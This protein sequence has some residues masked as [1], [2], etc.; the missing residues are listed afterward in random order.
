MIPTEEPEGTWILLRATAS[1][2]DVQPRR[3]W[4]RRTWVARRS[5][6]R[7]SA[8]GIAISYLSLPPSRFTIRRSCSG[9]SGPVGRFSSDEVMLRLRLGSVG[10]ERHFD[11]G[12]PAIAR[13]RPRTRGCA[14]T[15]NASCRQSWLQICAPVRSCTKRS[16]STSTADRAHR[17]ARRSAPAPSDVPGNIAANGLHPAARPTLP[18]PWPA[19]RKARHRWPAAEPHAQRPGTEPARSVRMLF[20]RRGH[21]HERL[22]SPCR[23]QRA[24]PKSTSSRV[25]PLA[26]SSKASCRAPPGTSLLLPGS[27][28]RSIIGA[29]PRSAPGIISLR[30]TSSRPAAGWPCFSSSSTARAGLPSGVNATLVLAVTGESTSMLRVV[31][32]RVSPAALRSTQMQGVR[33]DLH[34][35]RGRDFK[36]ERNGRPL[37]SHRARHGLQC[38]LWIFEG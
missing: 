10:R 12:G 24:S 4:H 20:P 13:F 33:A 16:S 26:G 29:S 18:G 23:G 28:T 31:A 14:S 6:G 19:S 17:H 36:L 3:R 21:P 7:A 22:I 15:L 11:L 9:V 37:E 27:T 5:T 34:L 30:F 8:H 1:F 2:V 25:L 35:G 32:V 38:A